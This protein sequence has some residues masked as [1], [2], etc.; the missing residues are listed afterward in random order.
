MSIETMRAIG[1][2]TPE[3]GSGQIERSLASSSGGG[4]A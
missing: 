2:V 1:A 3:Q 4:F